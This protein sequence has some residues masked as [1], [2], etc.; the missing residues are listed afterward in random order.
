L[1]AAGAQEGF[2]R[3]A[4]EEQDEQVIVC[5]VS[6]QHVG[7]VSRAGFG[8]LE[9]RRNGSLHAEFSPPILPSQWPSNSTLGPAGLPGLHMFG[10]QLAQATAETCAF[11][12]T[13]LSTTQCWPCHWG[14]SWTQTG[15]AQQVSWT[16]TGVAQQVSW[17]QTGV[18][19]A[20]W[21]RQGST[22]SKSPLRCSS[23]LCCVSCNQW[24]TNMLHVLR[25]GTSP[26]KHCPWTARQAGACQW[27]M[28]IDSGRGMFMGDY[29]HQRL[30][31]FVVNQMMSPIRNADRLAI[32]TPFLIPHAQ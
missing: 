10:Q 16:Q 6:T 7:V 1:D 23:S 4:Q 22:V 30:T 13:Q 20:G 21:Y 25:T 19:Q 11:K 17:T 8:S 24:S 12:G 9:R 14:V 31:P 29:S 5:C 26:M 27:G 28:L 15:V 2:H 32:S 18:A 3:P